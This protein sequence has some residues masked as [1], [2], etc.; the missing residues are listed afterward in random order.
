MSAAGF[1]AVIPAYK[2]AEGLM[3]IVRGLAAH[4]FASIVVVDDGS[5][6]DFAGLFARVEAMERVVVLRHAVNLGKGAALKTAFNHLVVTDPDGLLVTLDAD[7]QHAVDDVMAV[8]ARLR[9]DPA[10]LVVGTRAFTGSVPLRSRLGNGLTRILFGLLAGI[11]LGDT[12]SGLRAMPVT[13]ARQ[14]LALK[15]Q[16]YEFELDMLLTARHQGLALVEVSIRTIYLDGNAS[17]HFNPVFDSLKIYFVLLRFALSSVVAALID[18]AVFLAAYEVS[19]SV[20]GSQV[21]G[22]L[23]ALVVNYAMVRNFVFLSKDEHSF[24]KYVATVVGLGAL[25]YGLIRLLTDEL[26]LPVIA[27]KILAETAI[28]AIN[29]LIQRDIVFKARSDS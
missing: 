18:N 16:R 24:P 9:A 17:S 28:Y 5:G 12:Q 6:P 7:G 26:G 15:S 27:A 14:L 22:R 3:D 25:S 2:P 8:A 4:P 29:F 20:L 19:A 10:C 13:F 21:A 1:H 23:V 11:R